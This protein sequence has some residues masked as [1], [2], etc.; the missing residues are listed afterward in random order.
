MCPISN[1]MLV[2]SSAVGVR[3]DTEL[4]VRSVLPGLGKQMCSFSWPPGFSCTAVHWC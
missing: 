1:F 4:P 2:T 3:P